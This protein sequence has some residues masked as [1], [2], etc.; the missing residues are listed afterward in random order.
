MAGCLPGMVRALVL[1]PWHC[2][3]KKN[4]KVIS[5]KKKTKNLDSIFVK[6]CVPLTVQLHKALNFMPVRLFPRCMF[7]HLIKIVFYA[8]FFGTKD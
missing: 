4:S 8:L 5:I 2:F 7:F 6:F 1:G 3:E